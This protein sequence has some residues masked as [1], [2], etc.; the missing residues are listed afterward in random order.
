MG[1]G[2]GKLECWFTNIHNGIVLVEFK[3]LR[4]GRSTYFMKQL[5]HKLG[6]RTKF[7]FNINRKIPFPLLTSKHKFISLKW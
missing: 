5:T 4:R 3:N 7:I 6:L 2:K 1:K